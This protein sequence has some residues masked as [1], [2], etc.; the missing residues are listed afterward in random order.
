MLRATVASGSELGKKVKAVMDEGKLVDDT[1]ICEMVDAKLKEPE[2]KNGFL[3]DGFPRTLEQA[4]MLTELLDKN[5]LK[6]NA[7]V[8]FCVDDDQILI[9]RITGRLIHTPSGRTYH[10]INCPPKVPMKDDVTGEDL[11][12]RSDDNEET[13]RRRLESYYKQTK[14]LVDYYK[15]RNLHRCIDAN[16]INDEVWTDLLAA[17]TK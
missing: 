12:H 13:L 14:P 11:I 6:L 9:D 8:E 16:K 1:L 10:K 5:G 7:V 4:V 2:C 17:V 3:L 15:T